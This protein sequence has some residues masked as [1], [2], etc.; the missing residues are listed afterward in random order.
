MRHNICVITG[1]HNFIKLCNM[2]YRAGF[3]R[4]QQGYFSCFYAHPSAAH[5]HSFEFITDIDKQQKYTDTAYI[6]F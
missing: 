3:M 1:L 6:H 2:E 5:Y 4:L